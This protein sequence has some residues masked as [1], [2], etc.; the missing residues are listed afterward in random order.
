MIYLGRGL[1][2][3]RH[4]YRCPKHQ[5]HNR[6]CDQAYRLERL[7][8]NVKMTIEPLKTNLKTASTS[9]N[10]PSYWSNPQIP[11]IG[12]CAACQT[13]GKVR[14][15]PFTEDLDKWN[16]PSTICPKSD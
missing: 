11:T 9:Q 3:P 15:H 16:Q 8:L 2:Q 14:S 13:E 5:R 10:T 6:A 4:H 12:Y 1:H 7:L